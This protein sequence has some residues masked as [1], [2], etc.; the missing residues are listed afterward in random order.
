MET[1]DIYNNLIQSLRLVA[2][3]ANIQILS[4]PNF[5]NVA[6]EIALIYSE[7]YIMIPQIS[8]MITPYTIELLGD[9]D[10]LFNKMSEDESLWNVES[11]KNDYLWLKSRELGYSILNELKEE[12]INPN[13]D[14]ISWV[15]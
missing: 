7:S 10:K 15:K 11:L 6:D 14:F 2:S 3:P 5:V 12:Y 13:L 8:N 1:Q 9:L 4:L